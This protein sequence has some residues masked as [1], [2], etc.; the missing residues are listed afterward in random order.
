MTIYNLKYL[1]LPFVL[2]FSGCDGGDKGLDFKMI[3]K[4]KSNI[5]IKNIGIRDI[6]GCDIIING[7]KGFRHEPGGSAFASG[8]SRMFSMTR[9]YSIG[10]RLFDQR[11]D[12]IE[13]ILVTCRQPNV[14]VQV[15]DS[16]GV[17]TNF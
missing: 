13:A 2:V 10:H 6:Q 12:Q 9:F 11:V 14:S 15:Y 5:G 17:L 7:A 1:L 4:S 16:S 3:S 8:E